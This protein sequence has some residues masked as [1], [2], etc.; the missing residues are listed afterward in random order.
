MMSHLLGRDVSPFGV[1]SRVSLRSAQRA[2][3]TPGSFGTATAG[4][5]A[6]D[7]AID[8]A[9]P[10]AGA[11]KYALLFDGVDDYVAVRDA[12]HLPTSQITVA[13]WIRVAKHKSFNRI[14]SH[15]WV[16]WGWNLYT[17]ASG[18]AR[19][20]IG[21]DN[22]DFAA[23]RRV[24]RNRWHFV[25]G[26][27]DGQ[28]IRVYVDGL[29]GA[30]TYLEGGTLDSDGYVSIGGAEWD[31]F[32]GHIDDVRLYNFALDAAA[33]RA[34]M[35]GEI[36]PTT[37][38][39]IGHWRFDEGGDH[40]ARDDSPVGNHA[41]LGAGRRAPAWVTSNATTRVQCVERGGIV[42]VELGGGGGG[43]LVS[44]ASGERAAAVIITLPALGR[45]MQPAAAVALAGVGAEEGC[46]VEVTSVPATVPGSS[47]RVIYEVPLAV[48]ASSERIEGTPHCAAIIYRVDGY[49]SKAASAPFVAYV[50]IMPFGGCGPEPGG[51]GGAPFV[52]LS[53]GTCTEIHSRLEYAASNVPAPAISIIIPMHNGANATLEDTIT[54]VTTQTFTDWEIVIINDGS[55]DGSAAFAVHLAAR[56]RG[57]GLRVRVVHK[58]NGGLADARNFGFVAARAELVLPLDADD[59]IEP[60]FLGTAHRLLSS[61]PDAH[62][63]IANLQGFGDW[64]YEW[65]LPEYDP[66]E[67]RYTNM[68]HCSAL[69][70]RQI[71][72]KV[73]GGYPTTTL[74]GFE[75]WAFW[76]SAQ[77]R[78]DGGIVPTYVREDL[79]RYRLRSNS[80]LQS[81]LGSQEYSLASLR[82]LYPTLYP[83]D[84][85]TAAHDRF[86]LNPPEKVRSAVAEKLFKFPQQSAAHLMY[87]LVLEGDG[88]RGLNEAIGA[89][90]A[91]AV[92]ARAGALL[93]VEWEDALRS[94][95]QAADL[96][97]HRDWQPR[98]RLGL[99]LQRLGRQGVSN[100]TFAALFDDFAGMEHAYRRQM[101]LVA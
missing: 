5:A 100:T 92:G 80:M 39:L 1:L 90:R 47:Q 84:L 32:R 53:R 56:H 3:Y 72:E 42:T 45:V 49:N 88:N 69:M 6:S 7:A 14:A 2:A 46:F 25:C 82:V 97:S 38:G 77:E 10:A 18:V 13:G 65:I 43:A 4:S 76:L 73:P 23:N 87:G 36:S 101:W 34:S 83:I 71:W 63:A 57:E 11:G 27:Y 85:L 24:F 93:P 81:L 28:N 98:L 68:F 60:K 62:L 17:D 79:F 99:L 31:P 74:F 94:Y 33:V 40:I 86:L 78:L 61:H 51:G 75:D 66:V 29:P 52:R 95:A 26:T 35:L 8:A 22:N 15:E 58:T 64:D 12:K 16:H 50:D 48:E 96:A 19:F 9:M 37:P 44:G 70:R 21:Q 55:T 20:G 41:L 89:A 67:L 59:L 54:S 91:G 30:A